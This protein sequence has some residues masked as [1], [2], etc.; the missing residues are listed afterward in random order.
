M[1][2]LVSSWFRRSSKGKAD[3]TPDRQSASPAPVRERQDLQ[4]LCAGLHYSRQRSHLP[5]SRPRDIVVLRVHF[6]SPDGKVAG[7]WEQSVLHRMVP[8]CSG[9]VRAKVHWRACVARALPRGGSAVT[10]LHQTSRQG[11]GSGIL[12][13]KLGWGGYGRRIARVAEAMRACVQEP[14]VPLPYVHGSATPARRAGMVPLHRWG[15]TSV[16]SLCG[17]EQRASSSPRRT[18]SAARSVDSCGTARRGVDASED[19]GL[20]E[21]EEAL[22]SDLLSRHARQAMRCDTEEG[23]ASEDEGRA[24]SVSSTGSCSSLAE[25]GH[26]S[27]LPSY[28]PHGDV[29]GGLELTAPGE[30]APPGVQVDS[31]EMLATLGRGGYGRVTLARHKH[32]GTVYA[33]KSIHKRGVI[34]KGHVQRL[35]V[36]REVMRRVS[37]PF[38]VGLAAAFQT[39][40]KAYLLMESCLGG[41]LF[42]L[43]TRRGLPPAAG[44]QYYIA[45]IA[46][47]VADLHAAGVIWRD[48]KIENILIAADGRA[49]LADFGLSAIVSTPRE[50][51]AAMADGE[52]GSAMPTRTSFCGTERYMSP[53]QLLQRPYTAAC[54][55]WA[56]G[57]IAAELLIGQHPF[58]RD[59][60]LNTLRATV[61]PAVEPYLPGLPPAAADLLRGLL[62]KD[63]TQR[64]GA[65]SSQQVL[66]H[67]YFADIDWDLL[68]DGGVTPPWVPG[69]RM[70]ELESAAAA[71]TADMEARG[72][73]VRHFDDEFTQEQPVDSVASDVAGAVSEDAF[74][75]SV[76]AA[77]QSTPGLQVDVAAARASAAASAK[78]GTKPVKSGIFGWLSS[79][80]AS[81][82]PDAATFRIPGFSFVEGSSPL[83]VQ[84][85]AA[86]DAAVAAGDTIAE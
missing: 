32:S 23:D 50:A 13:W 65:Q 24:G 11:Q 14:L 35:Y 80:T 62:R 51:A 17:Y 20:G 70:T 5:L 30:S 7:M 84:L 22:L 6:S 73:L 21:K 49:K 27:A 86:A 43:L 77:V 38:V 48:A 3:A 2:Q 81:P 68:R 33:L 54:D 40:N 74:W 66:S 41:D 26:V 75:H 61:A 67:P 42:T 58:Q 44:A 56:L 69:V 29:D 8:A 12:T 9:F 79:E 45:C 37:S 25:L 71:A 57:I 16:A 52:A 10:M 78:P 85:G 15:S 72:R 4:I 53:N 82:A 64:L 55:W 39:D 76:A 19:M 28:D 59:S 46:A 1:S 83:A 34:E 18:S 60:H 47:G 63:A 36:E 31:L